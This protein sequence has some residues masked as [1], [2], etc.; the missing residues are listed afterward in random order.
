MLL[1]SFLHISPAFRWFLQYWYTVCL[2]WTLQRN[3]VPYTLLYW[4]NKSLISDQID[5]KKNMQLCFHDNRWW[6]L[7]NRV[8]LVTCRP[9]SPPLPWQPPLLHWHPRPMRVA[10]GIIRSALLTAILY[11]CHQTGSVHLQ[12]WAVWWCHRLLSTM[13]RRELCCVCV[14]IYLEVRSLHDAFW[15]IL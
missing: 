6:T 7:V 1:I 2:C 12:W 4:N 11:R 3:F 13:C 5:A 8:S 10:M 9:R 15:K 14:I